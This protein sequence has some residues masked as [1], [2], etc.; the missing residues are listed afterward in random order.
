MLKRILISLALTMLLVPLA[1][2]ETVSARMHFT[3]T[4]ERL[5]ALNQRATSSLA[6][7]SA[8]E[9]QTQ[10]PEIVSQAQA[11]KAA[12][13]EAAARPASGAEDQSVLSNVT[14]EMDGVVASANRA[15]AAS[16][17][18]QRAALEDVKARSDRSLGMVQSRIQAQLAAPPP[19]AS[20]AAAPAGVA[21]L[22]AAGGPSLAMLLFGAVAA[23]GLLALVVGA[24]LRTRATS[25]VS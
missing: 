11:A 7:T 8:A 3:T 17:A 15:L 9:L 25:K 18:D 5:E 23:V 16:G 2:S 19:A 10:V 21:T 4:R 6:L 14:Q 1:G 22:P 13:A 24:V 12:A 20:P